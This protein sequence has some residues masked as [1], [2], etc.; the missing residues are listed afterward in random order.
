[1]TQLQLSVLILGQYNKLQKN[2]EDY[3][4]YGF[5]D[6]DEGKKL[7]VAMNGISEGFALTHTTA[8][9]LDKDF[10]TSKGASG[11]CPEFLIES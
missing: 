9:E 4:E 6:S 10:I 1:L 5:W 2:G 11:P 7:T 8:E 3:C